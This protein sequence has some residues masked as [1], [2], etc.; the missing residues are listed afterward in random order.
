MDPS[1]HA[2]VAFEVGYMLSTPSSKH[3]DAITMVPIE[4]STTRTFDR[5]P[6]A[7]RRPRSR[8]ILFVTTD[9]LY[10][11]KASARCLERSRTRHQV[12]VC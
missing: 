2:Q 10:L 4:S 3:D 11:R 8:P 6:R 7:T 12:T 9:P 1:M 5:H